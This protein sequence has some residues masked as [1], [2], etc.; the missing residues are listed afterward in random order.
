MVMLREA[1]I[2]PDRSLGGSA[3]VVP[4]RDRWQDA[5]LCSGSNDPLFF[6][7]T[8][9]EANAQEAYGTFCRMCPVRVACLAWALKNRERGIWAGTTTG[10]RR[11]LIRSKSR[12]KCPSCSCRK[13]VSREDH[14]ICTACGMSWPT[15]GRQARGATRE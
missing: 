12:V 14:D 10:Q 9:S 6:P 11:S 15:P 4:R 3:P 5:A 8:E 1:R 13:L 7:E 2:T